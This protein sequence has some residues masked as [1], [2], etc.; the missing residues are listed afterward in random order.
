MSTDLARNLKQLPIKI[1]TSVALGWQRMGLAR[2]HAERS[3][4]TSVLRCLHAQLKADL[5][6]P[7][8]NTTVRIYQA[9][10]LANPSREAADFAVACKLGRYNAWCQSREA[11]T[12]H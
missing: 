6:Q 12:T 4:T 9:T 5:I 2:G 7:R 8:V 10:V 3:K 11:C 1:P